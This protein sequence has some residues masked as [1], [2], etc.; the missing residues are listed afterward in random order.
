MEI[1]QNGETFKVGLS[2]DNILAQG[3]DSQL[4]YELL[5]ARTNSFLKSPKH[6]RET[7]SEFKQDW[8]LLQH[9]SRQSAISVAVNF[10][11]GKSI[12]STNNS[13]AGND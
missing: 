1:S 5:L 8:S 4:A 13:D 2:A 6:R 11:P 10:I 12:P 7:M 3:S 9:A